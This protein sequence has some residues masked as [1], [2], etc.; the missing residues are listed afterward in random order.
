M[1]IETIQEKS[2]A[3]KLEEKRAEAEAKA[4]EKYQTPE[5]ILRGIGWVKQ[6][7]GRDRPRYHTKDEKDRQKAA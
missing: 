5:D 2:E 3:Q 1:S 6:G 7:P 4:K